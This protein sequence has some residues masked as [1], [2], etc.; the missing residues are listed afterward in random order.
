MW[1][2]YYGRFSGR[3]VVSRDVIRIAHREE[4]IDCAVLVSSDRV[5]NRVPIS[6]NRETPSVPPLNE[7]RI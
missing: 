2:T 5:D 7:M 1:R 3:R 4:R 6:Q